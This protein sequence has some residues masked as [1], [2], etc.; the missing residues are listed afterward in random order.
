MSALIVLYCD[1]PSCTHRSPASSIELSRQTVT[2][3]R[4][5]VSSQGWTAAVVPGG[6]TVDYAPGHEPSGESEPE[7]V[8][9]LRQAEVLVSARPELSERPWEF[10]RMARSDHEDL[11]FECASSDSGEDCFAVAQARAVIAAGGESDA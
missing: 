2:H 1:C 9:V 5:A 3:A 6:D 4:E 7:H 11:L 10:F 8:R